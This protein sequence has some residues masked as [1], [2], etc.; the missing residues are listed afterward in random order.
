MNLSDIMAGADPEELFVC[1]YD[2]THIIRNKRIL[3]YLMLCHKNWHGKDTI[4]L[5]NFNHHKPAP[6]MEY[7]KVICE[8][9]YRKEEFMLKRE[10]ENQDIPNISN[11][12]LNVPEPEKDWD[13]E[14]ENENRG[15]PN[16]NNGHLN[17]PEPEEDWDIELENKNRDIPNI[18]NGYLNV[19]I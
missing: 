6:E 7:H 11:G 8:D 4:C 2:K 14:L 13:M 10:K 16:I 9:R 17:V 15:I 1:P 3:Y 18:N 12:D 5:F 19:R